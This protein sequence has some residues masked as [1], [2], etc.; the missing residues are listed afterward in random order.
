MEEKKEDE[1]DFEVG[2][3]IENKYTIIR[4][5]GQGAFAKIYLVEDIKDKK[6]YAAKILSKKVPE[7]DIGDFLN[8]ISI[9]NKLSKEI[10]INKYITKYHDSGKGFIKKDD[11]ISE[12]RHYLISNYLSK[13][14]LY[15][16]LVKTKVGFQ[17]KHAKIIFSKILECVQFIHDSNI[18]HLDLSLNNILLDDKYNP[19]ITDFGLS[20]ELIKNDN[21]EYELIDDKFIKGTEPYICPDMRYNKN[22][23]NGVK[24]D[25]FSLGVILFYLVSNEKCFTCT[26]RS[27][28]LFKLIYHKKFKEY[29]KNIS[30]KVPKILN[31]SKEFK[32]LFLKL[33]SFKA[34]HR[35]NYVKDIFNEP[36]L[37]DI[38]NLKNEDYIEYET[39]MKDLENE[40]NKDNETYEINAKNQ[41]INENPNSKS[42]KD[43]NDIIY[44]DNKLKPK[45][46]EISGLNA[47]NYIKINGELEPTKFMNT[48]ANKL[49]KEFNCKIEPNYKSL[50]FEAI[51]VNKIKNEIENQ[52]EIEDE[53]E[54]E[55]ESGEEEENEKDNRMM[56]CIIKIEFFEFINGG[57]EVHFTKEKGNFTD[58][59]TYFFDVKRTI[60]KILY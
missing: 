3:I 28:M 11:F 4:K 22:G 45:Y 43:E 54:N 41:D 34:K 16:Y 5:I 56:D 13:G 18:C 37:K 21:D 26:R 58:Y 60:K 36:W 1:P 50:K 2:S 19:I 57:Y 40:I 7:R 9:L 29:W 42:S 39:L 27:Q 23:Y 30:I 48:L 12:N 38:K 24:A 44:F 52:E 6:E 59:Y 20:N 31:L 32:N 33:V 49:K 25:I 47:M 53:G 8:E 17:E 10:N 35:P 46:L 15:K 51:F 14:N 55:E